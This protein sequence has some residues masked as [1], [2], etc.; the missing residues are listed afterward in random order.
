MPSKLR[1]IIS[2]LVIGVLV[3]ELTEFDRTLGSVVPAVPTCSIVADEIERSL[4]RLVRYLSA[5]LN[6]NLLQPDEG[7]LPRRAEHDVPDKVVR[8]AT[9]TLATPARKLHM[10]VEHQAKLDSNALQCYSSRTL[11]YSHESIDCSF[12]FLRAIL[13]DSTPHLCIRP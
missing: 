2:K 4:R 1:T 13:E 5:V 12:M 9:G 3:D 11:I 7:F 6:S 10:L 8:L